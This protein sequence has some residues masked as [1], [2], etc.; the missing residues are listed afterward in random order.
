V[1]TLVVGR[2]RDKGL[3]TYPLHPAHGSGPWQAV[4]YIPP[5]VIHRDWADENMRGGCGVGGL[6]AGC[7]V[8]VD[9]NPRLR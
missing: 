6:V 5:I 3:A 7:H 2:F 8:G 1:N 9:G 4:C